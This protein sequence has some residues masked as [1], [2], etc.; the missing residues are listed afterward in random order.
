MLYTPRTTLEYAKKLFRVDLADGRNRNGWVRIDARPNNPDISDSLGKERVKFHESMRFENRYQD[1]LKILNGFVNECKDRHIEVVFV[2]PPVLSTYSK[3]TN[4]R[5]NQ[6]N[7]NAIL[8]LCQKYDC[9]YFDYFRDNRFAI[10]DFSD[11]DHLNYLGAEKFS[12]IL[13]Q[14]IESWSIKAGQSYKEPNH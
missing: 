6:M 13:N 2:V 10:G 5:I 7:K 11:N 14:D 9:Q 3:Y 1:N 4:P 12:K 8:E